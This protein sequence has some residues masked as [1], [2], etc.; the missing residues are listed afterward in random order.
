VPTNTQTPPAAYSPTPE[1]RPWIDKI[2]HAVEVGLQDRQAQ[3][4]AWFLATAFN[5]GNQGSFWHD[6]DMR[7]MTP[8]GP[9]RRREVVNLYQL[10]VRARRAKFLRNKMKPECIAA[11]SDIDDK[12]NA[13]STEKALLYHHRRLEMVRLYDEAMLWAQ[14]C[15][16]GY[17]WIHW[18]PSA[19]VRGRDVDT[20]TGEET[21][22]DVPL[23]DLKLEV[24]SPFEVLV[25]D[26]SL[27]YIG[28]QPY[29]VRRK[30]RDVK[31]VKGLFPDFKDL[32]H[33]D[34]MDAEDQRSARYLAGLASGGWSSAVSGTFTR[35]Y[36]RGIGG[37][38]KLDERCMVTEYFERPCPDYPQGIYAVLVNGMLVK[39]EA[40]LPEGFSD[41]TN[42]Y[43]VVDFVDQLQPGQYWS[44]T[45]AEQ[46]IGP[47]QSYNRVR[48]AVDANLRKMQF[49]KLLAARQHRLRNGQMTDEAGEIVD[50]DWMPGMPAPQ[51]LQ[52]LN[53]AQDAWRTIDLLR[54]EF[55]SITGIFP[56]SIGQ[57]EKS[58]SGFQTN[59]VQEAVDTI[60][61]PD[62]Q[63]HEM[64]HEDCY[65]KMRRVMK[66]HYTADRLITIVGRNHQPDAFIFSESNI[67]EHADIRINT[68]SAL[69]DLKGARI[70]ASLEMFGQGALGD[71]KNPE[72]IRQLHS[73]LELGRS[74]ELFDRSSVDEERARLENLQM[75]EGT[76]VPP[77]IFCDN[78]EIHLPQHFDDLKRQMDKRA[79]MEAILQRVSHVISHLRFAN[80]Q[81]AMDLCVEYGLPMPPPPGQSQP[82]PMPP[83]PGGQPGG[84]QPPPGPGG[85]P[86]GPPPPQGPPQGP[87][88]AGPPQGPGGPPMAPPGPPMGPP[89]G[90]PQGPPAQPGP[91]G[92]PQAPL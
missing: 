74:D 43:P 63:L 2:Q 3:E 75:E 68:G 39:M 79:P 13:R 33:G 14:L 38:K 51:A 41:M 29:I 47:Q 48:T 30:I 90:P 35:T 53:I 22:T 76:P 66:R 32:I 72:T 65:R 59:L 37:E 88:P 89:P 16:H 20:V 24:G 8:P 17:W 11:T 25:G 70:Q 23:G 34:A 15:S 64:A 49:P 4:G 58:T 28:D 44:S 26:P 10:Y 7:L 52:P 77:A 21:F 27:P 45:V 57:I 19:I 92:P 71:P 5:R 55:S 61:M 40:E 12:L 67:D 85:P 62:M 1:Q 46:L 42:P 69:P 60:H 73:M 87:P 54:G 86:M 83:P 81:A 50:Y 31:V 91:P 80:Y 56:E 36:G 82:P 84:P 18:D 6:T 78:H 9:K